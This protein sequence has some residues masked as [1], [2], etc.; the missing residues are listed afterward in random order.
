M[1]RLVAHLLGKATHDG[2][3]AVGA[4]RHRHE[5]RLLERFEGGLVPLLGECR[6]E[7]KLRASAAGRSPAAV[8][9]AARSPVCRS[10]GRPFWPASRC[11]AAPSGRR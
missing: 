5:R 3:R 8:F 7:R 10:S 9:K 6:A 11:P 4:G 1:A 2:V